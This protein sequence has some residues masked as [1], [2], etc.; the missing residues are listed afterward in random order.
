VA[1]KTKHV[2]Q[3]D[4]I[5]VNRVDVLKRTHTTLALQNHHEEAA[6]QKKGFMQSLKHKIGTKGTRNVSTAKDGAENQ[7]G[8]VKGTSFRM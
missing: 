6:P 7:G 4:N 5:I 8:H 3:A 2:V 1:V